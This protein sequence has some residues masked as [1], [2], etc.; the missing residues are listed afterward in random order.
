MIK[1]S[2]YLRRLVNPKIR[3]LTFQLVEFLYQSDR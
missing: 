2:I 3:P 1:I